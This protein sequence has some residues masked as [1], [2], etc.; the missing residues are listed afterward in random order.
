MAE[1]SQNPKTYPMFDHWL[2]NKLPAVLVGDVAAAGISASL[3][4]PVITAI[5]R[6]VCILPEIWTIWTN[7][8]IEQL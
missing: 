5:D 2:S 6:F 1:V 3:I 7:S 8:V 4:S